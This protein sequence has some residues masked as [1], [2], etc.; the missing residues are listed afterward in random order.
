M[1]VSMNPT[2]SSSSRFRFYQLISLVLI[3]WLALRESVNEKLFKLL[4]S[5]FDP[6]NKR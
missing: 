2:L 1:Q 6:G 5:I 4:P 3:K